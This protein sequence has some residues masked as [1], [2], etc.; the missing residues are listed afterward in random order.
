LIASEGAVAKQI[1]DYD[2]VEGANTS[3]SDA[4]A[5]EKAPRPP[6]DGSCKKTTL[7]SAQAISRPRIARFYT[8]SASAHD[9]SK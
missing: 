3:E 7:S 9:I 5:P 6:K 4:R 1:R 8:S 2:A